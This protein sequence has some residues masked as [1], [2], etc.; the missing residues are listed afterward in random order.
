MSTLL[1]KKG[2]FSLLGLLLTVLI[3]GVLCYFLLNVYLKRPLFNAE[4][5]KSLSEQGIDSSSYQ[6]TLDSTRKEI[7][8]INRKI[9][10]REKEIQKW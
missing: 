2:F 8:N 7:R 9:L 3:I 4:T 10:E 6:S 5:K 1:G